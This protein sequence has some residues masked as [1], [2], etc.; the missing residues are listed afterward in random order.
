[1]HRR[2]R[3]YGQARFC[4]DRA[5]LHTFNQRRRLRLSLLDPSVPVFE[6]TM[7]SEVEA[8]CDA[9]HFVLLAVDGERAYVHALPQ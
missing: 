7:D 2:Q 6:G 1:M 5:V 9:R 4:G 3:V 8:S